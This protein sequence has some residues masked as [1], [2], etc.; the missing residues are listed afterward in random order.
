MATAMNLGAARLREGASQVTAPRMWPGDLGP[1]G[2]VYDG[3]GT[4]VAVFSEVAEAV[5]MCLFDDDGNETRGELPENTG[6]VWH[7]YLPDLGA[8]TRYG[9]RVHGPWDPAQ[10]LRCNPAKL[11]LDPYARA[12]QG[13]MRWDEAVFSHH[14]GAEGVP[15]GHARSDR[16]EVLG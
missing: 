7:G 11:L 3:I 14:W 5:E 6:D 13:G 15:R 8:G 10:G 16:K 4:S 1:L 12:I 9:F 2:A